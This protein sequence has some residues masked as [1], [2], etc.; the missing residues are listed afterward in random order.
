[1]RLYINDNAFSH[2]THSV[3]GQYTD[4]IEWVRNHTAGQNDPYFHFYT[5]EKCYEG[6]MASY[7][8]IKNV[9]WLIESRGIIPQVYEQ[10]DRVADQ[11]DIILT[12]SSDI[13]NKYPDKAKWIFGGGSYI[14]TEHGGGEEQI[15]SKSKFC[16]MVSSNKVMCKLHIDRL[17]VINWLYNKR[18]YIDLFGTWNDAN[19]WQPIINSLAD[20]QY[21]VVME[22]YIDDAF[23]TEKLTNCFLTG[24]IPIYYGA[25][26]ISDYF[27]PEGIIT[28]SSQEEL[29]YILSE[30]NYIKND[31]YDRM[32]AIKDNFERAKKYRL[33]ED[34]I[35][36]NISIWT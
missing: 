21:S 26:K 11:F 14:G 12:H 29:G 8:P 24:T 28:F 36:E 22:N 6:L 30:L 3:A 25:R 10:F 15:Y 2:C 33:M 27:N 35:S 34:F 5:N 19:D 18:H 7:L 20:Y 1:M 4:K 16:S 32:P 23:W 31:Y 13:L 9:A 17:H